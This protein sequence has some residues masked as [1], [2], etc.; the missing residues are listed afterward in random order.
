MQT[1][2]MLSLVNL[3][4]F[5]LINACA[6]AYGHLTAAAIESFQCMRFESGAFDDLAHLVCKHTRLAR[7]VST[8]PALKG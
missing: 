7:G 1:F 4:Q 6:F 2:M 5:T 8:W 3:F